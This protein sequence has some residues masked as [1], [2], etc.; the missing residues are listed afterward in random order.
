MKPFL[1][2]K[3][4]NVIEDCLW[5]ENTKSWHIKV[6]YIKESLWEKLCDIHDKDAK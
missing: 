2:E 3:E 5:C 1:T 4:M 6:Q